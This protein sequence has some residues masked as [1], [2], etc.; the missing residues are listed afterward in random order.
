MNFVLIAQITS[1]ISW[2]LLIYSYYKDDIN[3]LLFIQIIASF[4]DCLSYLFLGASSGLVVSIME[5]LKG[6]GYYKTD[7]DTLIFLLTLPIYIIMAF[8]TY[9]TIFSLL[10]I[11]A[12]IIDGFSLTKNK[13][14]ATI[15]CII[16]NALWVV[17]DFYVLAYASV[18]ADS[19]LIISNI[20]IL[21]LGYSRLL[22]SNKLRILQGRSLT[23]NLYNVI[24]ELDKKNY[25]LEYTW[26][27]DYEKNIELKNKNSILLIKSQNE[28]VGYLN[29]LIINEEE[30]L[31]IINSEEMIKEYN[32]NNIIQ[33][34]KSKNNYLV[35]DSINVKSK[36]HN[37][38]TIKLIT[39]K[40]KQLVLKNYRNNYKISSIIS[41]A[42][43][44]FEKDVLEKAGFSLIKEYSKKESLYKIDETTIKELY[45]KEEKRDYYNYK[46]YEGEEVTE[47][48]ILELV[49]L[50][51]KFFKEEYLWDIDYQIQVFNKNKNSIITVKYKNKLIGYLNYLVI[52]KEKY[53]EMIES[54]VIVDNFNL[55]DIMSFK[56][57]K[58]NYITINSVVIDKKFQNGYTV[59]LLTKRLKTILKDMNYSKYRID[60]IN[61]FAVSKDGRHFLENLGFENV[62]I[63]SDNN[64]LFILEGDK[65]KKYLK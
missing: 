39:K 11:I 54:D 51:K 13:K 14:I 45:L 58:K 50:D 55:D 62:K 47:D 19:V 5:L 26:P 36:F 40:I 60:G 37:T 22:K 8:L 33:L 32:I 10:P 35:I 25:G 52:T 12:S 30:Y 34:H 38:V 42:L 29:Y 21:L 65:L 48:M 28:I 1:L 24:Y 17:Y 41:V 6:L 46:V 27:F 53:D 31:R 15:G 44:Q 7:K 23:K 4:F 18:F 49:E 59:K 57:N 16:S 2:G 63:L 64:Y 3:K 61:A 56:K 9:D 20:S 43:N